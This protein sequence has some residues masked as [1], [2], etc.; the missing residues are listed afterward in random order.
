MSYTGP[1]VC[2][3]PFQVQQQ[4]MEKQQIIDLWDLIYRVN[5]LFLEKK[6]PKRAENL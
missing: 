4:L 1:E 5:L 6:N 3:F 2:W